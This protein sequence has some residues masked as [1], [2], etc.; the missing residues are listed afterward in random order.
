MKRSPRPTFD[1]ITFGNATRDV[2]LRSGRFR[3]VRGAGA[4]TQAELRFPLG[5]K[6]EVDDVTFETG[7]GATNSAVC[8]ARLGYRTAFVGRIGSNDVRG[9]EILARL[10]AENIATDLVNQ[11]SRRMTAY[12]VIL[13]T[14]TGE[15][16]IF[17]YRGASENISPAH[18][19]WAKLS[20]RWF[21]VTSLGG[22]LR[23]LKLIMLHAKKRG[24]RVAVNPG[25]AE[26]EKGRRALLPIIRDADVLLLNL[27][28][29]SEFTGIPRKKSNAIFRHLCFALPGIV[30]V[31]NGK[32][33][34]VVC[35]NA[36][37]YQT[38]PR[39]IRVVD[40]CGAGDAFG[41]GFVAAYMKS[42]DLAYSLKFATLNSESV[43]MKIGAK[44]GLLKKFPRQ[45]VIKVRTE[46]FLN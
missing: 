13:L 45:P 25:A 27:E 11:D 6:I 1:V 5:S 26:L 39:D 18:I 46:K 32:R 15:R 12:S 31:T 10:S 17:V 38:V 44:A 29:A 28:E 22:N 24:I 2:F 9:R 23:L 34:A 36:A 37:Q 40:S 33:G 35:D 43:I 42:N 41:S 7:G 30:V 4:A 20:S 8:F 3:I 16:T 21:Y 14:E 19:P